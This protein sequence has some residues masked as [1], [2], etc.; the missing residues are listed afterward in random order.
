[1]YFIDR[2]TQS[3]HDCIDYCLLGIGALSNHRLNP[4]G[5]RLEPFGLT[6]RLHFL[7]ATLITPW[8]T[9]IESIIRV[10]TAVYWITV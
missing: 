10:Y 1:M 6:Y 2:C 9:L 8:R 5:P 3:L 4:T 7:I